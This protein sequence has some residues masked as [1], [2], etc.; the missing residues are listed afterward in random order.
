[1]PLTWDISKVKDFEELQGEDNVEAVITTAIVFCTMSIGMGRITEENAAEFYARTT[2]VEKIHGT[3]RFGGQGN[4]GITIADVRRR[5][6]L[7]TNVSSETR[8]RWVKLYVTGFLDDSV[9]DFG[10]VVAKE[11]KE[12]ATA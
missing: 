12:A 4:M 8:A 2:L 3:F 6:G 9:R 7:T 11:E 5:I 10:R 1:M